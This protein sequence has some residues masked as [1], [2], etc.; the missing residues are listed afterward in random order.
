MVGES[1]DDDDIGM[2]LIS[3]RVEVADQ[4]PQSPISTTP[5][6]SDDLSAPQ[7]PQS[8]PSIVPPAH[9][10][11]PL[12]SSLPDSQPRA[13]L[14]ATSQS[15]QEQ[16][17]LSSS[18]VPR[19]ILGRRRRIS[20]DDSNAIT[21][22]A[23]LSEPR[24]SETSFSGS[25]PTKRRRAEVTMLAD[26]DDSG[27]PNGRS[28]SYANG[29]S[30]QR[31]SAAGTANGTHKLGSSRNGA[32]KP[33]PPEKYFNH[34]REEVTRIL[35]QALSD[36]GY[37]SAAQNVSET[38]GYQLENPTVASFR[39]AILAGDWAEAE[40]LLAG[41]VS[42]GEAGSSS[43][44]G[45]VLATGA[46]R[47]VMKFWIRQQKYLELLERLEP[48]QALMVLRH[49]L[50]SLY[51]DT[52]KL[53]FLS[54]LIMCQSREELRSKASWDGAN[55]RS[56]YTLLSE[57]SKCISPSVMLPEHRLAD[58]LDQV[59]ESQITGCVWHSSGEA[60]S[61]YSDHVCN[62]VDFPTETVFEL[63]DHAGEVWQVVFSHDGTKLAS[64][65][66]DKQV[67][68][69]DVPSFKILHSLNDHGDGVGNV[70]W[71]WDDS[72]LVSCCRDRYA[73]LWDVKTGVCLQAILQ[74]DEPVSSCVWAPDDMSF[75]IGSLDKVGS[76]VQWNLDAEKVHDWKGPQRIEELALSP[77]GR[78]LVAMDCEM[79][80]HVYNFRTREFEYKLDLKCRLTSL[81][82]SENSRFLLVYQTNGI[83]QLVDLALRTPIQH[84]TGHAGGE[85]VI[86][87]SLGGAHEM[88]VIAGSEDGHINIWSKA[89]GQ[90]IHKLPAHSPR[91]N[92]VSWCPTN[93]Q[94]FA[95]CGDDGKIKIWSNDA[96]RRN[97]RQQV[98]ASRTSDA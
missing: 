89:T 55:G 17:R 82:I 42:S 45:L 65:G 80:I 61:L 46:D 94:L 95:S 32:S 56:R 20:S 30:S 74:N 70:A 14:L 21:E 59:K 2:Y 18:S 77:N 51:K 63:D 24:A 36:M 93:P 58:L 40:E 8:P 53:H 87:A 6:A 1:N 75:I 96:W 49:E 97:Q 37:H 60:P 9:N 5:S 50:T 68:I 54:S 11:A 69:W 72:M 28:R 26:A 39:T 12:S 4:N 71:S 10:F 78:W 86:R 38:S 43:N 48:G 35:I 3:T 62:R 27:T 52:P 19:Q 90:C 81:S 98:A 25:P 73:R 33:R 64:C 7:S 88:F 31:P 44:S 57:L 29:K 23:S 66:G 91:C 13:R 41:T 76:L 79:H 92:S 84:Y 16:Q 83:A 34:D 22:G 15:Q 85:F 47:N 67:I